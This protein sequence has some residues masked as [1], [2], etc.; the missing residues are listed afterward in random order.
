MNIDD[1]PGTSGPPFDDPE[2]GKLANLLL[3]PDPHELPPSPPVGREVHAA[4]SLVLRSG[5]PRS[6]AGIDLLLIRRAESDTDPWSGHMAL[7]GG[8]RD[9]TDPDLLFT[10]LRETREETGVALDRVGAP[11]GRLAPVAP[12]TPRLPPIS[13][14]PFV[15][16]VG[17]NTDARVASREVEEVLWA[18]LPDLRRAEARGT[19]EIPLADGFRTFPCFRYRER[20]VWGLTY[21]ILD[22]FFGLLGGGGGT[23]G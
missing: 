20:V 22:R 23:P 7:P 19:V 11:L 18:P 21:R 3:P 2:L 12:A 15:F 13:I 14:F 1:G 9:H 8:R 6:G 17:G 10:A 4:V 5:P 16:G